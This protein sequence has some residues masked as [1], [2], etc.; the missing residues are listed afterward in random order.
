VDDESFFSDAGRQSDFSDV[1][2][3]N[4]PSPIVSSLEDDSKTSEDRLEQN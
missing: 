2:F 3:L 4:A 1:H